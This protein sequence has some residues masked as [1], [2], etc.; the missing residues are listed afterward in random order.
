MISSTRNVWIVTYP[1]GT[2]HGDD[3]YESEIE[4]RSHLYLLN[5]KYKLTTL[6]VETLYDYMQRMRYEE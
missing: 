4:A 5:R 1:D 6:G 3:L 2:M